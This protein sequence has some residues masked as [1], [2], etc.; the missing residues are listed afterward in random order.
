MRRLFED[1]DLIS[2]NPRDVVDAYKQRVLEMVRESSEELA[3]AQALKQQAQAE[4]D[5]AQAEMDDA[6]NASDMEA[7]AAAQM[8]LNFAKAQKRNADQV[9]AKYQ[10]QDVLTEEE[11]LRMR[12]D[13]K[14]IV[15]QDYKQLCRDLTPH[16]Q[17]ALDLQAQFNSQLE[18]DG[19]ILSIAHDHLLPQKTRGNCRTKIDCYD[20]PHIL[21]ATAS[22]LVNKVRADLIIKYAADA[23]DN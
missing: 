4:M 18:R 13:F 17:A 20:Y 6:V 12:E 3:R 2:S 23:Q 5:E 14:R 7:Y 1:F 22:N 8:R 9:E 10:N 16:L 11:Y 15:L 19:A 21:A